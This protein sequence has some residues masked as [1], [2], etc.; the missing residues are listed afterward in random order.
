MYKK[1]QGNKSKIT[2]YEK[3]FR[4]NPPLRLCGEREESYFSRETNNKPGEETTSA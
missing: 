4:Q 1:V 2:F 3:Y